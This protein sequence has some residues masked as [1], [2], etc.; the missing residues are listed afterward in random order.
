M[1]SAQ[2]QSRMASGLKDLESG[3]ASMVKS[4]ASKA[5]DGA[6]SPSSSGGEEMGSVQ[7]QSSMASSLQGLESGIT[8]ISKTEVGG[9]IEQIKSG[10]DESKKTIS[11]GVSSL[12]QKRKF[13]NNENEDL[14]SHENKG[15]QGNKNESWKEANEYQY[16]KVANKKNCIGLDCN[17]CIM[18]NSLKGKRFK[19][20]SA[21]NNFRKC[22]YLVYT[23]IFK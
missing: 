3:I 11:N 7:V 8:K 15:V 12:F 2:G 23:N 17:V 1:G 14:T 21:H 22:Y 16:K 19:N 20:M 9:K 10:I 13:N 4:E 5:L 6:S 18:F